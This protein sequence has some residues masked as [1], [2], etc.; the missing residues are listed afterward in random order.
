MGSFMFHCTLLWHA[1]V[2]LDELPMLWS[3][4]VYLYIALKGGADG[5][6]M[7]L[8]LLTSAIP[9][10][11][12]WFYLRYPNPVFH[13]ITYGSMQVLS[14]IQVVRLF[15]RLPKS[16]PEQAR[17]REECRQHYYKGA[18]TFLLAFAIWNVDNLCCDHLT[19]FRSQHGK[20]V[21]ALTQGHAWWHLLTCLGASR[22]C[23]ALTYLTRS[24]HQP[25]D[26]EFAS[27]LGHPYVRR[28]SYGQAQKGLKSP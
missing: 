28:K 12:S 14:A 1:Q 9:A 5:G 22:L 26:F 18:V 10:A 23:V 11:A 8:K 17:K 20:L 4:A 13:Q 15:K 7:R 24:I 6:N 19:A 16:T 27:V 3:A 2:I 21:G 25:N